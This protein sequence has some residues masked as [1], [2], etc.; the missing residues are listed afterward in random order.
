MCRATAA[1]IRDSLGNFIAGSYYN[2]QHVADAG[3]AEALV[4]QHGLELADPRG[5]QRI[6]AQSDSIEV[7]NSCSGQNRIWGT[8]KAIFPNCITSG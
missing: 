2:L 1:V 6:Q 8:A 3:M 7:I 5:M 4:M